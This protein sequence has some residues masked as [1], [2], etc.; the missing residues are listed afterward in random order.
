MEW[1]DRI[2]IDKIKQLSDK[3]FEKVR[4]YWGDPI[5]FDVAVYLPDFTTFVVEK[6][7]WEPNHEGL[8]LYEINTGKK[9]NYDDCFPLYSTGQLLSILGLL[10]FTLFSHGEGWSML[11]R[12]ELITK[13]DEFLADALFEILKNHFVL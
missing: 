6:C 11:M 4:D 3:D 7:E 1:K 8:Y 12:G 13:T 5:K 10:S 2:S 9:Y